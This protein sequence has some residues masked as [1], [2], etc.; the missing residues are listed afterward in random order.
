MTIAQIGLIRSLR[1][2]V[3]VV[4]PK[5]AHSVTPV[6]PDP[7]R[8]RLKTQRI[9]KAA[10][11]T[12]LIRRSPILDS[13]DAAFGRTTDGLSLPQELIAPA[14]QSGYPPEDV[15]RRFRPSSDSVTASPHPRLASTPDADTRS[16]R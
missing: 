11:A 3:P 2:F 5:V 7:T 13:H 6:A 15:H 9:A 4:R 10:E 8:S 12:P 14:D 1:G 16:P